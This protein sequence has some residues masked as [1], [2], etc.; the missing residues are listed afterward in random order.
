MDWRAESDLERERERAN[1]RARM[2]VL[3]PSRYWGWEGGGGGGRESAFKTK[4]VNKLNLQEGGNGGQLSFGG[5]KQQHVPSGNGST[6]QVKHATA[7]E[8]N[9]SNK[10]SF[11]ISTR[12]SYRKTSASIRTRV[13][14]VRS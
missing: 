10:A 9:K 3:S 6:Q 5:R 1:A 7:G 11:F 8:T 2:W 13:T 12:R 14:I 4:V